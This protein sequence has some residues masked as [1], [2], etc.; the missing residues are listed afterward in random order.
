[1]IVGDFTNNLYISKVFNS[2]FSY[3]EVKFT[4]Q[5]L[6][7]IEIKDRVNLILVINY[8]NI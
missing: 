7:S 4:D 8:V 6:K 5:T 2:E 3:T 1:M